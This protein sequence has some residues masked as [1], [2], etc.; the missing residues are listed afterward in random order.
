MIR[1]GSAVL[2]LVVLAWPS[3]VWAGPAERPDPAHVRE[4]RSALDHARGVL[5]GTARGDATQAL[6]DL[7]KALPAL[8]GDDAAA[9]REVLARPSQPEVLCGPHTC[10]HWKEGGLLGGG[11]APPD[12]DDDLDGRPDWVE[13]TLEVME[14]SWQREVNALGY[15]APLADASPL[16][17]PADDIP[18]L[19]VY[20]QNVGNQ[21]IYGYAATEGGG[22]TSPAY[23]VL[24]NDYEEFGTAP[25][26]ALKAT[27]A[28]ELFHAVQ[29]AYDTN[30]AGWLMES[31]ATWMEE[32]VFDAVND[33]RNYLPSSSLKTPSQPLTRQNGAAEYG[34]WVFYQFITEHRG[35]AVVKDVWRRAA[36]SGVGARTAIAAAL[37]ADGS[38]LTT[39]FGHF[40]TASNIPGRYYAEGKAWPRADLA[41]GFSFGPGDTSSGLRQVVLDPL[42]AA[43]VAFRP[44][45]LSGRWRLRVMVD[46]PGPAQIA[47]L[48]VFLRDGGIERVRVPSGATGKGTR[49]VRFSPGAVRKVVLDVASASQRT[50]RVTRFRATAIR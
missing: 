43:N 21:G 35:I 9:A 41:G 49:V 28:H 34:N 46:T 31:T 45:S 25:V 13:T 7:R 18:K 16:G 44:G 48:L 27:A 40:S 14:T 39:T 37:R 32:Q 11:D 38:G 50:D 1:L 8:A 42:T 2:T 33:N 10:V 30:E 19:D 3:P 5:A 4:A 47:H 24:D 36:R 26:L 15:R 22:K 23:L 17:L 6:L 29:F 12:A 20:L